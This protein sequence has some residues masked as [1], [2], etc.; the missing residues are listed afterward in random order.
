MK[1]YRFQPTL[2]GPLEQRIYPSSGLVSQVACSTP[3]MNTLPTVSGKALQYR[4][5][6]PDSQIFTADLS[7][8]NRLSRSC[9]VRT[10]GRLQTEWFSY[11]RLSQGDLTLT[12][13]GKNTGQAVVHLVG[14]HLPYLVLGTRVIP[15]T[16]TVTTATGSFSTLAGTT[17]TASLH[18]HVPVP[19]G[20][21]DYP[22][23]FKLQFAQTSQ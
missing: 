11:T 18:L 3:N 4:A 14:P 13:T 9:V 1:K 6:T 8:N 23:S 2:L 15:L 19:R 10:Q 21:G 16:Y 12:G 5:W 17:G 22:G 20:T 7:A